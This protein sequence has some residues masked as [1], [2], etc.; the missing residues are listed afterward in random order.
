MILF[1]KGLYFYY[2]CTVLLVLQDFFVF[3]GFRED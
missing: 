3:E 2:L 1:L